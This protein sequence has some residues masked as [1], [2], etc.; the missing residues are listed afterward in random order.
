ML[1]TNVVFFFKKSN[2][3]GVKSD[4]AGLLICFI[5]FLKSSQL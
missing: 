1:P 2:T 5:K 3:P 4:K